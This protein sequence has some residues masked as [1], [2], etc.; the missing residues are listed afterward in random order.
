VLSRRH[1]STYSGHTRKR[2]ANKPTRI[3][4]SRNAANGKHVRLSLS[5]RPLL[6]QN[7]MDAPSAIVGL[8]HK[9]P[10]RRWRRLGGIDQKRHGRESTTEIVNSRMG[11]APFLNPTARHA[12]RK[13]VARLLG[14]VRAPIGIYAVSASRRTLRNPPRPPFDDRSPVAWGKCFPALAWCLLGRYLLV[15]PIL[16]PP[17]PLE[18]IRWLARGAANSSPA[19]ARHGR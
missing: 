8:M 6:T 13:E 9:P 16:L 14:M 2:W 3:I 10:T 4:R 17:D 19:C 7:S 11:L 15:R 12:G 18:W 1:C 5:S